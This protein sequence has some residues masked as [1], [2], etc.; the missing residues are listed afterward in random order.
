MHAVSDAHLVSSGTKLLQSQDRQDKVL[1]VHEGVCSIQ[2]TSA[3]TCTAYHPVVVYIYSSSMHMY[4]LHTL[5][6]ELCTSW[7]SCLTGQKLDESVFE[8]DTA[9]C[10]R[11]GALRQQQFHTK[12]SL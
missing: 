9:D 3:T 5:C 6:A 4:E 12:S 10:N 11:Y 2:H 7:A 8:Q 1:V